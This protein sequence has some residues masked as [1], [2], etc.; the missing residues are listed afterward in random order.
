VP[1]F[2][3]C[4]ALVLL[5]GLAGCQTPNS[6]PTLSLESRLRLAQAATSQGGGAASLRT[7]R[8]AAR[9]RPDNVALLSQW[10]AAAE[11]AGEFAEAA[12]AQRM[13]MEIEGRTDARFASIGRLLLRAGDSQAAVA[14]YRAAMRLAPRNASAAN[15]LGLSHDMDGNRAEAQEAYRRGLAIAPTD[16]ALRSNL[17]MS[18]IASGASRQA[19]VELSDAEI[20][21]NAPAFARHNLAL[22]FVGEGQMERAVRVLRTEMGPAEARSMA[23]GMSAF[24]RWLTPSAT[25]AASADAVITPVAGTTSLSRRR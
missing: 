20:L 22:A 19:T 21:P 24:L 5:L 8:D 3:Q 17:A 13:V 18:L 15:G 14:A 12:E 25:P 23:E 1:G 2:K 10:A 11:Q 6:A 16:W 9:Q 4:L 7:M